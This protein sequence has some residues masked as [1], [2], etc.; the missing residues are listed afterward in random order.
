MKRTL[1]IIGAALVMASCSIYHPQTVDIPLL[2]APGETRVDAAAGVSTFLFMPTAVT[3]GA[4]ATH[5]FGR[6][7]GG[8][9]HANY[10]GENYYLQAAPGAYWAPGDHFR[11]E[12]Y[13]GVG[14]GGANYKSTASDSTSSSYEYNGTF[15]LPYMQLNLG[16]RHVGPFEF[17]LGLKF[18]AF[19]PDYTYIKHNESGDV[20][21]HYTT[22]NALFEPQ[23]QVRVGSERVKY[24]LRM[25]VVGLSDLNNSNT[26]NSNSDGSHFIYS[27]FTLSNGVVFSF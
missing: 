8:Q 13:L 22:A 14:Y 4:T 18:G 20:P 3:V 26:N 15:T 7:L 23:L 16:W 9:V 2:E 1:V 24:T 27:Q 6:W 21:S 25:S 17:A 10:G 19:L 11:M 5:S 12:G